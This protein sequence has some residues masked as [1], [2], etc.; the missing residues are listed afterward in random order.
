MRRHHFLSLRPLLKPSLVSNEFSPSS[1]A[2]EN[3]ELARKI[4][5]FDQIYPE[6]A[7]PGVECGH[8]REMSKVIDSVNSSEEVHNRLHHVTKNAGRKTVHP[9]LPRTRDSHP[10][11][12]RLDSILALSTFLQQLNVRLVEICSW[13][14]RYR[15]ITREEEDDLSDRRAEYVMLFNTLWLI[16]NDI[17]FGRAI[18]AILM[19]NCELLAAWLEYHLQTYTVAF[20]KQAL[21]WTNS[22][23]VGLKLNDQLGHAFCVC[24]NL[25]VDFWHIYVL[26]HA[27]LV[28][29]NMIWAVGFASL[30]G[31]T[32]ALAI[33]SDFLAIGTF[34][35]WIIYRLFTFIFDFQLQ[36]LS[37]LFNIFRGRKYNVLRKRNE[38]A[39]YQLDQLILG[40]ILFTLAI[41]LFPTILAFYILTSTVRNPIEKQV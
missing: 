7:M 3:E 26:Q 1:K 10:I 13:P 21:H 38:P 5:L 12:Y 41:F 6:Y 36:F 22:Y 24:S 30:F 35:L 29:P 32:F 40:T 15:K 16:A 19:E 34:H 17:I 18:G 28:L 14:S 33:A 20:V 27:Y 39:T 31:N 25:A 9:S 2:T 4:Q 37:V 23:P 11:P 8:P